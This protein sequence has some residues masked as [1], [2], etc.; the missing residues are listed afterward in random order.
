M[1]NF[2]L[3]F[4]TRIVFGRGRF[5]QLGE[6]ARNLGQKVLLVT[7]GNAVPVEKI[8]KKLTDAGMTVVRYTN[9]R[10]NPTIESVEEGCEL[11]QETGCDCVVGLGG[12]STLDAS[13]A[14]AFSAYNGIGI[15]TLLDDAELG[16]GT[17]PMLLVPTTAGTGSEAN[18]SAV[19]SD[20]TTGQKRALR[21]QKCFARIAL[22]DPE[23]MATAPARVIATT[24]FD[25]FCHNMEAYLSSTS[26]A[27]VRCVALEA[28]SRVWP[29]M[30]R[31]VA[32]HQDMEAWEDAAFASTM[33]GIVIQQSG[34]ILAH[35]MANTTGGM[36]DVAHGLALAA[37]V[38]HVLPVL[39]EAPRELTTPLAHAMGLQ[40]EE[41][42][43]PAVLEQLQY[44]G[45][46]VSLGDM[47]VNYADAPALAR[48]TLLCYGGNVA[49]SPRVLKED[50]LCQ[51]FERAIVG[52]ME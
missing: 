35:G 23:L 27:F 30:R 43:I 29:A 28:I 52:G 32:C 14:I 1:D 47:G 45:I 25:A 17:F 49:H 39:M 21:S 3:V 4:P 37:I 13:K 46:R 18:S 26:N 40:T 48:N 36:F 15:R 20:H 41:E 2:E 24:V 31:V 16:S 50:E 19:L 44:A 10:P 7:D 5:E 33:G 42:I 9:I 6:L 34:C 51:V 38:P 11:F 12:G 8:E 22:V